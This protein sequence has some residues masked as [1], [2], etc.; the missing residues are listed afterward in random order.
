MHVYKPIPVWEAR[1]LSDDYVKAIVVIVAMDRE[2]Q[3]LHATTF[4]REPADKD[5]AAKWGELF[6]QAAGA[7]TVHS[8]CY[9]DFRATP[10]AEYKA[11]VEALEERLEAV[12]DALAPL[13]RPNESEAGVAQRVAKCSMLRPAA[14]W[15]ED[16]G[17]VLWWHLPIE[18]PP[19][20]GSGP[21]AGERNADGTPTTC[22][23]LLEEGFLTH[24]SPLPDCKYLK[25]SD[26][27]EVTAR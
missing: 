5:I 15:H 3:M 1:A 21:G 22:A 8:I 25:T 11:K 16:F 2:N 7:D 18:E 24:W 23:R 26:G 19:Y 13:A 9:E 17:P 6:A 4:G 27:T 20:V 10:E 14:E 12:Q